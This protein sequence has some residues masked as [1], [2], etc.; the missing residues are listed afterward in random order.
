MNHGELIRKL[1]TDRKISRERLVEGI[2][3]I[4]TLQ[5]FEKEGSK[6]DIDTL[7]NYLERMNIQVDDYYL[8]YHNYQANK[9]DFLRNRFRAAMLS[10]ADAL[11]YLKL[12]QQEYENDGDIFYLL[13]ILQVK[14]VAGRLPGFSLD[15][16]TSKEIQRISDYL[17]NVDDWGFFELATYTNCLGIFG[18]KFRIFNYKDVV[19][20]FRH[21]KGSMKHQHALIKFLI[22]SII[23]AFSEEEYDDVV[24]LLASLYDETQDSDFIKGRL[25]WRFFRRLYQSVVGKFDFEGSLTIETFQ[26]LGYSE[27]ADNLLDIEKE[28]LKKHK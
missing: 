20:R 17:N 13:L 5:R 9:K 12:L 14:Y 28:I 19:T 25:Y 23:L 21:F 15:K 27:D 3:S 8:E 4:S 22:N 16:V 24:D 11:K 2:H 7:W 1:R 26:M 6:I 18:S 10:E